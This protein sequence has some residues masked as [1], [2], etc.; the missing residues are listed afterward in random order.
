LKK[1]MV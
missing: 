1:N